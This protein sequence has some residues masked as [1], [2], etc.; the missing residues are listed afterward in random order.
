MSASEQLSLDGM[1]TRLFSCTPSRL[2][3]FSDCPRRYRFTYLDRPSPQRGPAWAHNSLGAAAHAALKQWWDLPRARRTVAAAGALLDAAW[4]GEGFR[5]DAQSAQWRSR[6]REWV[7]SYVQT[8]DPDDVPIGVERHVATRTTTLALSGRVDRIDSRDGELVIVDYKAG[9]R[10]PTVDDVRSSF[11]LAC[12]ALGAARTLRKP[13]HRVEL[14]HLRSGAVVDW[15]HTEESLARHVARAEDT[16]ADIVAATDTL[17][18][19][20]DPDDV[21]PVQP[22]RQCSWCDFRRH[23]P[24]G[25]AAEPSREPWSMLEV[26]ETRPGST[27][28]AA[29]GTPAGPEA[30][31][32]P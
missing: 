5:D 2:G 18:A 21:F 20:A 8:V 9:R 27:V 25:Q 12:Y 11:A 17:S 23:C 15:T 1:P 28:A 29:P 10:V 7:E 31:A 19:G 13:C 4:S 16:A 22:G 14:H 24:E 30:S 32:G 6:T 26:P 3:A